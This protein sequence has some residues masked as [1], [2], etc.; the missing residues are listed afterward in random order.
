MTQRGQ[1]HRRSTSSRRE[2]LQTLHLGNVDL[3][4]VAAIVTAPGQERGA[5][6][7]NGSLLGTRAGALS[8]W[9][10]TCSSTSGWASVLRSCSRSPAPSDMNLMTWPA[11]NRSAIGRVAPPGF[12]IADWATP[13]ATTKTRGARTSGTNAG[14]WAPGGTVS[15]STV[16]VR[17]CPA[18]PDRSQSSWLTGPAVNV[19]GGAAE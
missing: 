9:T 1:Q 7:C 5:G 2:A 18:R 4:D 3:A 12:T 14:S 13:S 11:A 16:T 15:R 17:S 6:T 8:A 19:D 10:V